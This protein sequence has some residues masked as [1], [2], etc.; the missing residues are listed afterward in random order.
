MPRPERVF[1]RDQVRDMVAEALG[2]VD[3]LD[4]DADLRVPAF[5]V[6]MNVIG[7]HSMTPSPFSIPLP[8]HIGGGR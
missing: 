1:S 6:C 7:Q 5:N 3:E 2:I 4:P 8:P